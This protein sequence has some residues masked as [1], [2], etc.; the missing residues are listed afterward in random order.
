MKKAYG[1][2]RRFK[3]VLSLFSVCFIFLTLS[4]GLDVISVVL[5][6]SVSTNDTPNITTEEAL[7]SFNYSTHKLDNSNTMG[8]NY[9]AY[10]IYNKNSFLDSEISSLNTLINDSNK[11]Q[12]SAI[13]L[14]NTYNYKYLNIKSASDDEEYSQFEIDNAA[15]EVKIRLANYDDTTD[16]YSAGIWVD[17]VRKGVPCRNGTGLTF[18]FGRKG[19]Y[20]SVPQK[21]DDD[22]KGFAD[23]QPEDENGLY[24]VAM[25][26]VFMMLDDDYATVYSPIHYLGCV[27]LDSGSETN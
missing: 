23:E 10:K 20:D 16:D 17:N 12:N 24:Y 25:F 11:K 26:S 15:H 9:V 3:F 13:S 6:D 22:A 21:T 7:R 19:K 8:K 5:D 1:N 2:N 14:L 4:C 18:D 27:Q